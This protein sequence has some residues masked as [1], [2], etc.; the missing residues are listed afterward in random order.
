MLLQY[1]QAAMRKA[2]YKMLPDNEGFFGEIPG[3]P[4]VWANATTL[5]QCRDELQSVIEDW[6]LLKLR[7]NDKDF[8]NIDGLD[9]NSPPAA[10]QEVA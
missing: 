4:G 6:I 7:H 3:F 8:P 5:E 10:D 9:L 1:I 2:A